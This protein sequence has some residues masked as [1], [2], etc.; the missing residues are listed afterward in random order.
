MIRFKLPKLLSED[1]AMNRPWWAHRVLWRA[2]GIALLVTVVGSLI[3]FPSVALPLIA[4]ICGGVF[5]LYGL[6]YYFSV[7]V[8]LLASSGNGNGNSNG[9][10]NGNGNGHNH[11]LLSLFT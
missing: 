6:K 5:F 7:A 3:A 4:L 11:R 8:V 10:G 1:Q 9:N 2:T